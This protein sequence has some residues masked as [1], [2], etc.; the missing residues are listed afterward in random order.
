MN[1]G[2]IIASIFASIFAI[3]IIALIIS[4]TYWTWTYIP[5]VKSKGLRII[6]IETQGE[7]YYYLQHKIPF[8]R[9]W[10]TSHKNG[11]GYYNYDYHYEIRS[12]D[13]NEVEKE[14]EII[15]NKLNAERANNTILNKKVITITKTIKS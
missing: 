12:T 1:A 15:V 10:R 3:L 2:E 8:F 14:L 5:T 11:N 6:E 9:V 13:R 7:T 4:S